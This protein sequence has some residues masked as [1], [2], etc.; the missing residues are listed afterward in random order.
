MVRLQRK[1]LQR[2]FLDDI[3]WPE[4]LQ[5]SKLLH[6]YL[7]EATR[8]VITSAVHRDLSEAPEIPG[9]GDAQE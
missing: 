7:N 2:K 4:Y 1:F 8:D 3:L 6:D 9:I 5:L